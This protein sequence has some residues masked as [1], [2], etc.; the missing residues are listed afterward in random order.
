MDSSAIDKL[1]S[2]IGVTAKPLFIVCVALG[3]LPA[4][5]RSIRIV[6]LILAG[7]I[8]CIQLIAHIIE[9]RHNTR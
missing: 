4:F 1:L 6:A 9:K 2:V 8:M 3:A 5:E 7:I